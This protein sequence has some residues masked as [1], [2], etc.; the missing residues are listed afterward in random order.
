RRQDAQVGRHG[1]VGPEQ[2]RVEDGEGILEGEVALDEQ[3]A[4]A[5]AVGDVEL[6]D[7]YP[8]RE[9]GRVDARHARPLELVGEAGHGLDAVLPSEA[10]GGG[11]LEAE[12]EVRAGRPVVLTGTGEVK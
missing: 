1:G 6:D 4:V 2:S 12:V 5:V 7:G 3:P 8:S 10:G 9:P 11:D